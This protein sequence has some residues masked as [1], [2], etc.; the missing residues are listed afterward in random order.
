MKNS[1]NVLIEDVILRD[2]GSW[3]THILHCTDVAIR[4]I[5]MINDVSLSN[6][7]GFDP[8]SSRDV[9]IEKCF[10][11]AGD[12]AFAIKTSNRGGFLKDLTNI[13]IRDNV[14][15]TQKSAL[16]IGT[17]TRA[18]KMSSITFLNNHVI[19]SDRGM[20]IYCNDGADICNVQFVGNSFEDNYPDSKQ[21]MIDFKISKRDGAGQIRDIL[22]KDCSFK[23]PFPRDSTIEGLDPDN[24]IKNIQFEN[25]SISGSLCRDAKEARLKVGA[26]VEGVTFRVTK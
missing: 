4:N 11:Y 6:T 19:Q 7:D 10:I 9:L 25:F 2:S 26:H 1:K 16:K 23:E 3:N 5:K 18:S 12:D 13:I 22:I 24:T 15:L 21:R 8:D 14:V 20:S 17:E